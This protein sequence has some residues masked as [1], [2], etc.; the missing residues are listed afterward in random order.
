MFLIKWHHFHTQTSLLTILRLEWDTQF[1]SGRY[2]AFSGYPMKKQIVP[3]DTAHFSWPEATKIQKSP[4]IDL[5]KNSMM[6]MINYIN[7]K[8]KMWLPKWQGNLKWSGTQFVSWKKP[9]HFLHRKG[10]TEE[11]GRDWFAAGSLG[12][13]QTVSKL[14]F[15]YTV[16]K[17]KKH[18]ITL[19][20]QSVFYHTLHGLDSSVV[21]RVSAVC[22]A[23][24]SL[25]MSGG[26]KYNFCLQK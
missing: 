12:F 3:I 6:A 4:K 21:I 15:Y 25:L 26:N 11:E 7:L 23:A 16:N 22:I 5:H 9:V 13:S 1:S 19:V 2:F 8:D 24:I 14:Y 18:L 17:K 10:I 20:A